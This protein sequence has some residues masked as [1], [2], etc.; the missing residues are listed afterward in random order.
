MP[1]HSCVE[2]LLPSTLKDD[3]LYS[4]SR[5]GLRVVQGVRKLGLGY[6]VGTYATPSYPSFA[7]LE[8]RL[9]KLELFGKLA[10]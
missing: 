7:V 8:R 9:N 6:G 3:N 4:S 5:L 10:T 2:L 1:G